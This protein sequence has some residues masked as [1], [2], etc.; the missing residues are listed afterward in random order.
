MNLVLLTGRVGRDPEIK[1]FTNGDRVARLSLATKRRRKDPNGQIVEQ[2]DWHSINFYGPAQGGVVDRVVQLARK[3]A[4]I[5]VKGELIYQISTL[6]DGTKIQRASI[7]VRSQDGFEFH[8][9]PRPEGETTGTKSKTGTPPP[10]MPGEVHT[11]IDSPD[12]LDPLGLDAFDE[13]DI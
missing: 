8:V 4:L 2:A 6:P 3:G 12:D 7:A 13:D 10:E 9:G 11:G 5:T 1:I